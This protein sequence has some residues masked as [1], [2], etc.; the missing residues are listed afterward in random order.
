MIQNPL[1]RE[2]MRESMDTNKSFSSEINMRKIGVYIRE[3]FF[4]ARIKRL[5]NSTFSFEMKKTLFTNCK[6]TND[7]IIHDT[8]MKDIFVTLCKNTLISL[9]CAIQTKANLEYN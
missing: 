3:Q 9:I 6:A 8:Q 5:R 2:N 4:E 7:Y 1:E